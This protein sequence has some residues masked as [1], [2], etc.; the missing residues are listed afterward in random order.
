MICQH[1][2]DFL[3]REKHQGRVEELQVLLTLGKC[4]AGWPAEEPLAARPDRCG[5]TRYPSVWRVERS[6]L[7]EFETQHITLP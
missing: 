1:C 7:K 3:E 5:R 4:P 6:L 2:D